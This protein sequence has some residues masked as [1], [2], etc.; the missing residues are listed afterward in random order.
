MGYQHHA[1]KGSQDSGLR[2][3][4]AL[5][6][7][8]PPMG[9]VT[10]ERRSEVG[11]FKKGNS[12]KPREGSVSPPLPPLPSV[13]RQPPSSALAPGLIRLSNS[14]RSTKHGSFDF[15][16][17]GWS[18]ASMMQRTG[19]AGS[20]SA[21]SGPAEK[22]RERASAL[23]PGMAGIGTLQ[24]EASRRVQEGKRV[25]DRGRER[26]KERKRLL[27]GVE[28]EKERERD[29]VTH[30]QRTTPSDQH[31]STS[32]AGGTSGTTNTNKTSS[33]SKATGKRY[34]NV[35][36]GGGS[37]ASRVTGGL[38]HGMFSF[39]PAVQTGH[40]SWS[41]GTNGTALT[42]GGDEFGK[43]KTNVNA[44]AE[45][46][47]ER[48]QL[49][50]E[51]ERERQR[52]MKRKGAKVNGDRAPVPVPLPSTLPSTAISGS[53]PGGGLLSGNNVPMGHRSGAK[54]RS[55]DLG[56]GL[57]WAS[58]RVP[59]EALLPSTFF[60]RSLS[61]G[62]RSTAT[63][64]TDGNGSSMGHGERGRRDGVEIERSTLK[65]G[66]EVAEVFRR[67][68]D[69]DGYRLFRSCT[70]S[71][72]SFFIRLLT[73]VLI[74]V[75]RFDAHEI[76][77]DGPNG[78]ISLVERLLANAAAPQLGEEGKKRLLDKFVKILLQQA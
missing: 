47:Y 69:A 11:S 63:T 60:V 24:K 54:G 61:G 1:L 48:V 4:V 74:D 3:R 44:K 62:Q 30:S 20:G 35:K 77:F 29:K 46:E 66:R 14:A 27:L 53:V 26:E 72:L 22:E 76:P 67:A 50:K 37:A 75:H 5:G 45:K 41:T 12:S 13:L 36:S 21:V 16:R 64:M 58:S 25:Q 28:R 71:F 15:E 68:L 7:G 57:A 70:S 33:A 59:E 32:T 19:S 23:A 40:A 31:G 56:L 38:Q 8:N 9:V 49:E 2:Y 39:E 34:T 42:G 6:A 65:L 78:I 52:E 17:P 73:S 18:S 10:E 55:L 43:D 51:R